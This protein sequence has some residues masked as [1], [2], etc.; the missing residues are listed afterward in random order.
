MTTV[1][2]FDLGCDIAAVLDAL[3]KEVDYPR[4][5]RI[6]HTLFEDFNKR[7]LEPLP[8]RCYR[9]EDFRLEFLGHD[10]D[11]PGYIQF[12]VTKSRPIQLRLF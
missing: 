8:N 11:K 2:E 1:Y 10:P 12:R 3:V 5:V 4:M 9:I 7:L 6:E